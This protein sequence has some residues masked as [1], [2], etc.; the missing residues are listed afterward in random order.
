MVV[1]EDCEVT[2][3]ARWKLS[4]G[5]FPGFSFTKMLSRTEMFD[6]WLAPFAAERYLTHYDYLH[7]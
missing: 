5:S 1:G 7:E 4:D 6:E 3:K 2:R